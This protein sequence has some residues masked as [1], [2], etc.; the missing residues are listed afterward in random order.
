MKKEVW[1]MRK[2]RWA[3]GVLFAV[4]GLALSGCQAPRGGAVARSGPVREAVVTGVDQ[5]MARPGSYQ[6][7]IR[8][9]GMVRTY[10]VYLPSGFRAD[11]PMPLVLAFHGGGGNPEAMQTMSGLNA[12]ADRHG[13]MVVYPAGTGANDRRL[14]W[15]ILLSETFAT[16]NRVDDIGF[17]KAMLAELKEALPVDGSRVYATG[18]SQGGMLCYRLAC[19]PELSRQLA[20]IA[21]VGATMTVRPDQCRA[22][23]PVPVLSIHGMEDPFSNYQGGIGS[24]A[25]RNDRVPRPGVSES[26]G[27][28]IRHNGLPNQ[29]VE[30]KR[31]G[32]ARMT[33][34]ANGAGME[35]INW[36]LEDGGHT[37]PGGVSNLPEFVMGKVNRD[38]LATALIWEFFS[39]HKR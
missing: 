33:R 26:V 25:P 39:R 24:R 15:N 36:T 20:A 11:A 9:N 38:V 29:P 3:V 30:E 5:P 31:I 13:F 32:R 14:S 23:N 19:D 16:A 34:F 12:M 1:W 35:V 8:F 7:Q 37:W 17:V 27:F 4:T 18:F 21:P 2:K 6:R 22:A 28:W 10:H